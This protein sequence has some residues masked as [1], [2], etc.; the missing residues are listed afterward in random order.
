MQPNRK[1][2]RPLIVSFRP[3]HLIGWG[4]TSILCLIPVVLWLQIHPISTI[5][6]FPS[7]MLSIGRITGLIGMVMYALNLVYATRLRFLERFFGGL[8]RVYIAHH[9]LGGFAL[10]FLSLHPLF[11][12]LRYVQSSVLQSALLL[13]PNGLTPLP[14][15]FDT[16]SE[17]HNIVLTQWAIFFGI[18][19][20][21]GMVVLLLVTFF[22]KL[23]Y[24]IWLFT[25]KFLGV[26]FFI[27]GLHV[28]FIN[29]DTTKAGFLKYYI[30]TLSFI[31]IVAYIY[32]TIF[33]KILIRH[34]QYRVDDVKIAGGNV[35]QIKMTPLGQTMFYQPGQ[36]VFIRFMF[37][38][39]KGITKEWHPFSISSGPKD[40]QLELSVKALGDYTG[41]LTQIKPGAIAEIEGAY[42]RFTYTHYGNKNQIWVAGGIGITPFLSMAKS[43]PGTDY[44]I[45]LYYSVKSASELINWDTLG[46]IAALMNGNFRV[47]PYVGDQMEGFLSAE[48]I[49][50]T[51]AGVKDKD[52]FICGPPPMMKGLRKQFR[53]LSVPGT[54]IHTEEFAMS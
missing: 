51:S 28:I 54:S 40:G 24:R 39:V 14:A 19:A 15:L 50:K 23:P 37:S 20:F 18:I 44:K 53:E 48:Y 29:S 26:A 5:H 32:R 3:E 16:S 45:D 21:W 30:L 1:D 8:N 43:L 36:F 31:G 25:H 11:L 41:A 17:Y 47:F 49:E 27:A 46:E 2:N 35:S 42:G 34:Y 22:V 7:V 12:S 4:V 10:I 38:G 13:L 6:T 52:I 33:G 9:V